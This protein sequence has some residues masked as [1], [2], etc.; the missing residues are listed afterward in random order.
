MSLNFDFSA[1]KDYD[2][3]ISHPA[4]HDKV[5]PVTDAIIWNMLAIDMGVITEKNVEEVIWRTRFSQLL[6]GPELSYNDGTEVFITPTDIRRHIGLRTNVSE[7]TRK[8]Y[9]AKFATCFTP[10]DI[11]K[12]QEPAH[13]VLEDRVAKSVA[14]STPEQMAADDA[15]DRAIGA[16][17]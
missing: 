1:I 9:L 8:N 2:A 3:V 12:T 15:E 11:G 6:Y 13:K 7:K 16:K 5:S 14:K 10:T 4:D 17:L